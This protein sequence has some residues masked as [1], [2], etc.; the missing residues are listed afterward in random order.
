MFCIPNGF[1][2]DDTISKICL[3]FFCL[4]IHI[5]TLYIFVLSEYLFF[6]SLRCHR[7]RIH[8]NLFVSIIAQT[9]IRLVL[10]LDQYAARLKGGEVEGAAG[11]NSQTIFDT[12]RIG[13]NVFYLMILLIL[14]IEL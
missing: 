10:Y 1:K 5:K 6:R 2:T 7:T 9:I 3:V 13:L 4:Q 8:R 14:T 12:V 11:S